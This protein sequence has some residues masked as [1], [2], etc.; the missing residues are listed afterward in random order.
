MGEVAMEEKGGIEDVVA[1]V[2]TEEEAMGVKWEEGT[3]SEMINVT[4]HTE[5]HCECFVCLLD[6]LD[7]E[8]AR[9][10]PAASPMASS[11]S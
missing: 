1:E 4:D 9:V 6:P 10:L 8:I 5:D 7:S 11:D 2:A 3:T